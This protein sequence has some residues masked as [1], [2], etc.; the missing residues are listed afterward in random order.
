MLSQEISEMVKT[1]AGN[2]QAYVSLSLSE[3]LHFASNFWT[4][5]MTGII[6]SLAR[7]F[8]SVRYDKWTCWVNC[9]KSR[10]ASSLL[11]NLVW[12][13]C[14]IVVITTAQLHSSK[15]ELGFWAGSNPARGVSKIR[16][17]EDIWQWSRLEVTLTAFCR[18][19]MPQRQL[20]IIIT[21]FRYGAC[22]EQG[23]PWH[24][25]KL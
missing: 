23:I 19:T 22:F 14:S 24:L 8:F 2:L 7:E 18:S 4:S 20:H 25:G 12:W 5:L 13:Y 15:P 11:Q 21:I 17:R 6:I 3:S 1:T 16:D 10:F 9:W